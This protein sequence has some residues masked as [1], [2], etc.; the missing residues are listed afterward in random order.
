ME[1]NNRQKLW[2]I[3]GGE[4]RP[5]ALVRAKTRSGAKKKYENSSGTSRHGLYAEV[6]CLEEGVHKFAGTN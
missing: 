3:F 6:M 4:E 1:S 2:V 5:L